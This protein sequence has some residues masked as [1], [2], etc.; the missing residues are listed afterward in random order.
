[1]TK[2]AVCSNC[3]NG[4]FNAHINDRDELRLLCSE[5]GTVVAY[6]WDTSLRNIEQPETQS[7]EPDQ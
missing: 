3:E 5:C 1:M 7:L 2:R 6:G 4:E